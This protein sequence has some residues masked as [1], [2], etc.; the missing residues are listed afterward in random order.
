MVAPLR[1]GG[2]AG[3]VVCKV[4]ANDP[5]EA[6]VSADLGVAVARDEKGACRAIPGAPPPSLLPFVRTGSEF[7]VAS[8][9]RN[10]WPS[11]SRA[12]RPADRRGCDLLTRPGVPRALRHRGSSP[13][14]VEIRH[15]LLATSCLQLA[16]SGPPARL[17]AQARSSPK[18]R[19]ARSV[20]DSGDAQAEPSPDD[21][22][23]L[24]RRRSRPLSLLGERV[25]HFSQ[26]D[27]RGAGGW[28]RLPGVV[29][30]AVVVVPGRRGVRGLPRVVA[31]A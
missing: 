23:Q 5:V 1:D 21:L 14:R 26:V 27:W 28:T 18:A 3:G 20:P 31:L 4:A 7:W 11:S 30:G 15:A 12:S 6:E 17:P 16:T 8:C 2:L 25:I 13:T 22:D 19:R 10:A 9:F 24:L 29:R